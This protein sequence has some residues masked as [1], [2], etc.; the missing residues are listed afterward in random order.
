MKNIISVICPL[1]KGQKY[2]EKIVQMVER[3]KEQLSS[4]YRV[5]LLFVNDFPE[6][7][8][9]L[10]VNVGLDK[11]ILLVNQKNVGIHQSRVN[12]LA[13]AQGEYVVFLDQDDEIAEYYLKSQIE[14]IGSA[15]AIVCNGM[16]RK[17]KHIYGT[18][19]RQRAE[20]CERK[21][22]PY[23]VSPGQVLINK[24]AIPQE[25]K[26]N[27]LQCN[28]CDDALLWNVMLSFDKVFECNPECL[29][30]H[31][32]DNENAS[33]NYQEMYR[34]L[35]ECFDTFERISPQTLNDEY[36]EIR[37]K[38][39]GVYQSYVKLTEAL[40]NAEKNRE[41]LVDNWEKYVDKR[42]AIYGYG[43]FGQKLFSFLKNNSIDIAYVVDRE[44]NKYSLQN[45]VIM[46][47][48]DE[49]LPQCDLIIVTPIFEY[50]KIREKLE[51]RIEGE[52]KPMDAFLQ[53]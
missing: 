52:I 3:N 48:P 41:K 43:Y 50:H 9:Q 35:K 1:Y 17:A 29:Y 6:E 19:E 12:G 4:A 15:D 45:E 37:N 39:L 25:W 2:V 13:N 27:I 23:I 46:F 49:D 47:E 33:C 8:I 5:E 16:W 28:G 44:K 31:V 32:E 21:Y 42:I 24:W 26:E 30:I 7:M 11:V 20:V 51:S 36:K 14:K 40:V 10:P 38:R 34:S 18:L 22:F 53:I